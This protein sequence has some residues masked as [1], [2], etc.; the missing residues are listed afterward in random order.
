MK[1][2][3]LIAILILMSVFACQAPL[4]E[5]TSLEAKQFAEKIKTAENSII[6]DVRTPNEF[7]KGAIQNAIN[8]DIN[9]S[10]FEKQISLLDKNKTYLVYCLSGARSA[11][12][13]N[14]MLK[15]DFKES[16]NLKGGLLAWQQ[17]NLPLSSNTIDTKREGMS[18]ADYQQL[19]KAHPT[20]LIDFYA[21][22]CAP[23]KKMEPML[24]TLSQTHTAQVKIIR[25]DIDQNPA[26]VKELGIVEIPILKLFKNGKET[27]MH[28]GF[29]TQ[30]A[31]EKNL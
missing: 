26:L 19:T 3:Q 18:L 6:L 24:A 25:I 11:S 7:A 28:N 10:D 22:W 29:T 12:A 9:G 4:K 2:N 27:W 14:Y 20:V 8:I 21:P 16:Y 31:I 1:I 17:N 13:V 30:E 15:N 23:C 5:G